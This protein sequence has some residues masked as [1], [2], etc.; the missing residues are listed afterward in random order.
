MKKLKIKDLIV[1]KFCEQKL[2][3]TLLFDMYGNYVLQKTMSIAKEPYKSKFF[4]IVGPIMENLKVLTFGQKLYNK[5]LSSFPE[6]NIYV[7]GNNKNNKKK[8]KKDIINS[9]NNNLGMNI[10][11]VMFNNG[12]Q[13]FN[14][15]QYQ[16]NFPM[17]N[18][19][20]NMMNINNFNVNNANLNNQIGYIGNID[21]MNYF[22]NSNYNF[23]GNMNVNFM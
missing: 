13:F 14:P 12:N 7:K 2:V 20:N 10:N 22:N 9:N 18:N 23:I 6:L 17:V 4:S 3:Q 19:M 11:N 1:E 21:K 5:L 15:Y 16:R 8:N